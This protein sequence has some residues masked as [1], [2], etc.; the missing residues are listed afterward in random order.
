MPRLQGRFIFW[1]GTPKQLIV[2]NTIVDEGEEAFLKMLMQGDVGDV[3]LGG[4]FYV[5]L[6]ADTP[7][8]TDVLTDIASEPSSA[9]GYAR[10]ALSRDAT[11][12]PTIDQV[13]GV[14]RAQSKVITF[15]ASGVDFD[16]AIDRAFLCNVI[17]G[18]SGVLF[19]YSGALPSALTVSDGDSLPVQYELYLD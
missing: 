19:A 4:N 1:P 8:E 6:C 17:S 5:G 9:G 18:T 12:F 11:G 3:A 7:A 2:P 14:F 13:S 16:T 10:L 15:T